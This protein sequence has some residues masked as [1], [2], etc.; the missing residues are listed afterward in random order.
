MIKMMTDG[1]TSPNMKKKLKKKNTKIN[2]IYSFRWN[3]Q[4]F[5]KNI[6][7]FIQQFSTSQLQSVNSTT[8]G[9]KKMQPILFLT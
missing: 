6:L 3:L 9:L 4:K 7:K 2:S 8:K 5:I 1:W